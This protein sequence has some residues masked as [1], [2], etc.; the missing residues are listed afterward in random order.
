MV[1]PAVLV[2][3]AAVLPRTAV[4]LVLPMEVVL[5]LPTAVVQPL[6]A[7]DADLVDGKELELELELVVVVLEE[8]VAG[9]VLEQVV[10]EQEAGRVVPEVLELATPGAT[11]LSSITLSTTLPEVL[12][13]QV[14]PT[15][16]LL[17]VAP[18]AVPAGGTIK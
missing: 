13:V 7:V 8:L 18:A 9:K 16:V 14:G 1:P 2:L 5:E 3:M 12:V 11:P 15:V 4:E 17:V 10:V 6:M